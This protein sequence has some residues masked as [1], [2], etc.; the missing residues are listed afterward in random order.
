MGQ[1]GCHV[2]AF[3]HPHN[4]VAFVVASQVDVDASRNDT[5]LLCV[6]AGKNRY[7]AC[8]TFYILLSRGIWGCIRQPARLLPQAYMGVM[9]YG[10]F[11]R[12]LLLF[13]RMLYDNSTV[14]DDEHGKYI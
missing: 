7:F 9:S 12:Y 5:I 2:F 1:R 13:R 14:T 8:G 10:S 11:T 6:I 4:L 3:E